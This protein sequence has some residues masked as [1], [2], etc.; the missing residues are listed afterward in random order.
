MVDNSNIS[1]NIVRRIKWGGEA[2]EPGGGAELGGDG[3]TGGAS[4]W[5]LHINN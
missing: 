4:A 1:K 3:G 5:T 2:G